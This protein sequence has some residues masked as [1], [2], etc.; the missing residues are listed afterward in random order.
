MSTLSIPRD[1]V[2]YIR[3]KVTADADLETTGVE[4]A[5]IHG[6]DPAT[7]LPGVWV[8]D[9]GSTRVARTASPVTLD[10]ATYPHGSYAVRVRLT[11]SPETPILSAYTLNIT[12]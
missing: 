4:L 11:D 2:E 5:L 9:T 7:W 12:N 10:V 1:S 6:S 8:D 3:A